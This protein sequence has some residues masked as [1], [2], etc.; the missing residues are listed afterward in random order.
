MITLFD[1]SCLQIASV[2]A[3]PASVKQKAP[4]YC[5]L[6]SLEYTFAF[7][8]LFQNKGWDLFRPMYGQKGLP[9]SLHSFSKVH[10]WQ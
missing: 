2:R 5:P 3:C 4:K 10:E 6:A 7:V 9:Q 1:G 8:P